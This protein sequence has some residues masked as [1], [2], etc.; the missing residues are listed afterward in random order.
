MAEG[1]KSAG[2]CWGRVLGAEYRDKDT[3]G[4]GSGAVLRFAK[5][6]VRHVAFEVMA[7]MCRAK[8]TGVGGTVQELAAE[9]E[10]GQG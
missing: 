1:S 2:L 9:P 3:Q 6:E 8:L 7:E 5:T 4:K 10:R